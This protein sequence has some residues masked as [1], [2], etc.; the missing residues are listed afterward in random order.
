MDFPGDRL[1]HFLRPGI[2]QQIGNLVGEILGADEGRQRRH[3]NEEREQRHQGRER[4]VACD[5]PAVVLEESIEGTDRDRDGT[6]HGPV[7]I[8]ASDLNPPSIE[9]R[10]RHCKMSC[11]IGAPRDCATN[12]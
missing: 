6:P 8:G 9:P 7:R 2:E 12:L 10:G 5:R 4:D 11:R 3:Q 1:G